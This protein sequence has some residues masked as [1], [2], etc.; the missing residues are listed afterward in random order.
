M[1]LL[2]SAGLRGSGLTAD[3]RPSTTDP[4]SE[5]AAGRLARR[6]PNFMPAVV[7]IGGQWGDEG[8]GRIVDLIAQGATIVARYSAGNNAGHTVINDM[9]EFKLNVV[10]AGIFYPEKTCI[11]GNGV[12]VDPAILLN[13]IDTLSVARR[14]RRAPVHQR[15]LPRHHALA[16]ADRPRR[17]EAARRRGD[18]HDRTRRRPRASPTR[19]R[20]SASAW[21]TSSTRRRSARGSSSCCR[22]RT[23]CSSSSTASPPLDFDDV[24][25]STA[26]SARGCAPFV[27]DTSIIVHD[28][29]ERGET[30]L[31]EGAQGCLL[32]LDA[33]HVRVRD[34]VRAV[35]V[36]GR[37][38]HRHR[39][40]ADG[41]P[42]GRRHL[43]GVHDAR[44]QRPDADGA[45]RR[46]GPHPAG[47]GPAPGD[48]HD[49]GPPAPHRLVRRRRLALQRA[50][51]TA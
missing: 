37:R 15:P 28:A 9:G 44:R 29:L 24:S 40:R 32:D 49:D 17:R 11:I 39:H 35:V 3:A 45:A 30:I 16:P 18:R 23:R 41:D 47:R 5:G 12:A 25:T 20:A 42:A 38:R 33:R 21:A 8:K 48:R 14:Q 34:V 36:R 51:A 13:E 26:R 43:Q 31:L 6:R 7:V 50:R 2:Y 22:T 27:R 19:W 46:D 4:A 1:F 10:P